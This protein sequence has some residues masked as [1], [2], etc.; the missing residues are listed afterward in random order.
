MEAD[1]NVNSTF[2]LGEHTLCVSMDLHKENRQRLCD[3]LKGKSPDLEHSIVVLQGGESATQYCSDRE[4]VFRQESYFHWAFGVLEPDCYGAIEVCNNHSHLFVPRLPQEYAIWMG[5]LHGLEYFK[6]RYGVDEVHF[7]TDIASVLASLQPELLLTLHGK[8]TDSGKDTHEA[9]FAGIG[10]FRVDNK[11]LYPVITECRVFKTAAEL[12]VLRY[13]NRISSEAHKEVMRRI[14]L[15]MK[16]YQLE[17]IFNHFC[18]FMGGAR[19]SS[20]T[21]ICGTGPNGATLHYGHAGAP[22][23]KTVEDGD[24]CLFDMG[25]EYYCYTSDITC[26]FPSNGKFTENQKLIYEAVLKASRAVMD[27]VR[28]GVSW[29]SMHKLAERIQLE[30]LLEGGLLRGDVDKMM[31]ARLGAVFMPHGLGHFMGCDVHDVGGYPEGGPARSS[32]PG[33]RSLR[34][35]RILA[36][37]MVLTIEPGIYFIDY[38]LDEAMNDPN[39]SQFLVRDVIEQYRNFGGV[40]I[41]DDIVVTETGMELLTQVPRTVEEIEALMEEGQ[42]LDSSFPQQMCG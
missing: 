3:A 41:E 5:T 39:Q 38:L 31:E 13:I 18:Y 33:L 25:G 12:E 9:V 36:P 8:N 21:C 34:T 19:H 24:M 14:R 10:K 11:A 37:G 20:Y 26:S 22:N 1:Q 6:K 28:P 4:P 30:C 2:D 16:E 15:G 27:A 23:D 17:S 42:K 7:V 32:E 29:V 35:A 40:R